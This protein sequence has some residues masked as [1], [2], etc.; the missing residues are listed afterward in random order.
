[1]EICSPVMISNTEKDMLVKALSFFQRLKEF[2]CSEHYF[3]LVL[4]LN[5]SGD[6]VGW[7][8]PGVPHGWL[9]AT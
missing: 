3:L 6:M 7:P 4:S 2:Q 8:H 5:I 1:M 9:R